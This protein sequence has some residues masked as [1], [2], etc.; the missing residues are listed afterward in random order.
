MAK[1]SSNRE[2]PPKGGVWDEPLNAAALAFV[3]LEMTGL[4]P[5]RDRVLQVCVERVRGDQLEQRICTFVRPEDGRAITNS[6]IHGIHAADLEGAPR[7]AELV[8]PIGR[9]LQGAVLIAHGAKWDVAF[10][11]AEMSRA[12]Q[13]WTCRHWLCTLALARRGFEQLPSHRLEALASELAIPSPRPHRADNDVAVTRQLFA[14]LSSKLAAPTAR[15]LWQSLVRKQRAVEPAIVEAA[16]RAAEL[17][18]PVVVCYRPSG[19][20][21]KQFA[22]FVK[23]VRT[24]LDPPIVLGYLQRTRGRREL[25]ADRIVS[26]EMQ[27]P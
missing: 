1:S 24:D 15:A 14:Q 19:R 5:K 17:R 21:P 7:F 18:C 13:P 26:I 25:R 6:H 11:E 8:E 2:P 27:R 3:D 10:L 4:E 20:A 12:G 23:A 9:A 16:Q 22:F